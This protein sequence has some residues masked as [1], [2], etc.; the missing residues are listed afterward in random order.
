MS[1]SPPEIA[2]HGH[3]I[4]NGLIRFSGTREELPQNEEVKKNLMVH[5]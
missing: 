3:V 2:D 5:T 1:I 4:D